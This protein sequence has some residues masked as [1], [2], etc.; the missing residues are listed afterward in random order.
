MRRRRLGGLG[1]LLLVILI[2]IS[3]I[4]TLAL[5]G[6]LDSGAF[7]PGRWGYALVFYGFYAA[8]FF[9]WARRRNAPVRRLVF[10]PDAPVY[11]DAGDPATGFPA[12]DLGPTIFCVEDEV[13][14][15][16]RR[17]DLTKDPVWY[18]YYYPSTL[19]DREDE[20]WGRHR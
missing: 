15:A 18:L 10:N 8:I 11:S 19:S 2:W 5:L 12:E 14:R 13:Q 7:V 1:K 6:Y 3:G 17:G 16:R 4:D 9:W 20:F